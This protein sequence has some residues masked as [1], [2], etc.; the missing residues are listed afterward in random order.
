MLL[1]RLNHVAEASVK[2]AT[3]GRSRPVRC[4]PR[5]VKAD[6]TPASSK[7]THGRR[8]RRGA[9][10]PMEISSET[11]YM[12]KPAWNPAP[13]YPF[14][15]GLHMGLNGHMPLPVPLGVSHY[16][17][18]LPEAPLFEAPKL[19]NPLAE[20]PKTSSM[21]GDHLAVTS[22]LAHPALS[23]NLG[24]F[25][26]RSFVVDVNAD[27]HVASDLE[28]AAEAVKTQA[29]FEWELIMSNLGAGSRRVAEVEKVDEAAMKDALAGLDGLL[30][31]MSVETEQDFEVSMDSVR[32]K[33][34]KK[35][36]KHKHKKRR[37]ANRAERKR[38][39]K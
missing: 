9:I 32:R 13:L 19:G 21:V 3:R 23:S 1:R 7:P 2:P 31:R 38:L 5:R 33:R 18:K 26:P 25:A 36:S 27:A 6:L 4:V 30:A 12:A 39:R 28:K 37:K 14:Q 34:Q 15:A 11:P 22:A 10:R 20:L 35:M 17:K 16:A 8:L 29:D 24:S